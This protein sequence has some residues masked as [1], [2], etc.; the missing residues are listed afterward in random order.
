MLF[1]CSTVKREY[2]HGGIY[3]WDQW[4]QTTLAELRKFWVGYGMTDEQCAQA[5]CIKVIIKQ[6]VLMIEEEKAHQN[7]NFSHTGYH[8]LGRQLY[9]QF[10]TTSALAYTR[11]RNQHDV[12]TWFFA[13]TFRG[14]HWLDT[15][16]SSKN[17]YTQLP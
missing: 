12:T 3:C 4:E 2:C 10:E 11:L 6:K 1:S 15:S 7:N 5:S 9:K 14:F 13:S 8:L 17:L 16:I